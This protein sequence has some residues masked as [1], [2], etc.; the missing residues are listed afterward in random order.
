[1]PKKRK[2]FPKIGCYR[3][4]EPKRRYRA[5]GDESDFFTCFCQGCGDDNVDVHED[6]VI[7]GEP[8]FF[9]KC[10]G[11]C[12]QQKVLTDYAD[13]CG[14][15]GLE[16]IYLTPGAAMYRK[17]TEANGETY[18]QKRDYCDECFY[19]VI[20]RVPCRNLGCRSIGGHKLVEAT[21]G[22]KV[23]AEKVRNEGQDF[24]F[25]PN[26]CEICRRAIKAF[27]SKP[28]IRPNCQLCK[29]PFRITYGVLIMILKNEN[30]FKVPRE[31]LRCRDLSPLER[32]RIQREDELQG[33]VKERVR[34]LARLLNKDVA[35]LEREK[36]LLEAAKKERKIRIKRKLE[37]AIRLRKE[38]MRGILQKAIE[39]KT[40][41]ETLSNPKENAYREVQAALAHL[42]GGKSKMTDKEYNAL[43]EALR[44]VLKDHPNAIGIFQNTL[45]N[46][47]PGMSPVQ[48]HYEILA[49]AALGSKEFTSLNGKKLALYATD[50]TDFGIKS[51]RGYAQ[52]KSGGTIEADILAHRK[53]EAEIVTNRNS[54]VM[55]KLLLNEEKTIGIDTKHTLS[56]IYPTDKKELKRQLSGIRNNFNDGRLDEFF[57]VTNQKFGE[58][59]KQEVEKTNL[60][61]IKDYIKIHNKK[62]QN[63]EYQFLTSVEKSAMPS[64]R[65]DS[66]EFDNLKE[67]T[68][69]VREF[70]RKYEIKQVEI[71]EDVRY[72][73]T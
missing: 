27:K 23:F 44:E 73:G 25:P 67:Y 18:K 5:N 66:K 52:P 26:N 43:P 3:Y 4:Q 38:N 59:F 30:K 50:K 48:Q 10:S 9:K 20:E 17:I 8:M 11:N 33:L 46:R 39:D 62:F 7:F 64:N 32:K 55:D 21:F 34:R 31:C 69:E 36:K 1:M 58:V 51:A 41:Q 53:I 65:V 47:A 24:T 45:K 54:G 12:T 49:A 56:K 57:F 68:S 40:L 42:T 71:C 61:L 60:T 6:N 35:E 13:T 2:P 22:E 15:C 28:E 16:N 19:S 72:T 37:R 29:K 14:K 70:A 63:D